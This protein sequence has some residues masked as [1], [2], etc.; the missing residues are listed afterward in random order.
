MGQGLLCLPCRPFPKQRGASPLKLTVP[1]LPVEIDTPI[2]NK[3]NALK[4]IKRV[5]AWARKVILF[6][7]PFCA[8]NSARDS[9]PTS[10][11]KP[12]RKPLFLHHTVLVTKNQTHRREEHTHTR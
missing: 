2:E 8:V 9:N 3:R 5:D 6:Y 1:M 4:S 11:P 12:R 10:L 7:M